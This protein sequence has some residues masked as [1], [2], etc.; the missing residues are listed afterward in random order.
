MSDTKNN[1]LTNKRKVGNNSDFFVIGIGASAGGLEALK[2]FFDNLPKKFNHALVIVQHLSPD[3]KSLMAD[4]LSR[5]TD[6]PIH[7]VEDGTKV[8]PGNIYLIPKKKNMT[9][10]RGVLLLTDKPKSFDLNL[11]IDIFF[12]SLAIDQKEKSVCIV[13]SGTG[14]DGSRGIRV[15][16]EFGGMLMVQKPSDA[17][18]DGMPNSAIATDL[19]DYILPVSQISPE[20]VNFIKHPKTLSDYNNNEDSVFKQDFDKLIS[21]VFKKTNIDFSDYKLPTLIRRVE[22]RMSVNKALTIREY[23]NYVIDNENELETLY[24]EF[25][26]GVTKFFRDTEAF[27]Y[28]E[29]KLIPKLFKDKEQDDKIKIW[30]VGC[31]SGEEAYSLAILIREYIDNNDLNIDVK[32]FATDLDKEAIIKAKKGTFTQSI[33]ADV[34]PVFLNKYFKRKDDLYIVSPLIRKMIIFSEHNVAQDPPLTKMDL[35]TCRNVLIYLRSE[36]QQKIIS[37]FHYSLKPN[38]FLF[39]GPSESIGGF[40]SSLKVLSRKW[41]VFENTIPTNTMHLGYFNNSFSSSQKIVKEKQQIQ[42]LQDKLLTETLS[43]TLL[44]EFNAASAYVDKDFELLTA[45]GNFRNFFQFPKKKLR[46]FNILKM[47]SQPIALALSTAIRKA[48]KEM[49]K[50]VYK[51]I[52]ISDNNN[53]KHER[54]TLVVNPIKTSSLDADN[55]YLIL[56]LDYESFSEKENV[57]NDKALIEK[58]PSLI[59]LDKEKITFLEQELKDTKLNLQSMVEQVETSNEELQA[60][61]EELLSSNEELQSTNEELQSL[62]EE[63]HTVNS[64]YQEKMEEVASINSDLENL[65]E[66]THIGTIFLDNDLNIRKFTPSVKMFFNI[67]ETDIGR[68][69]FHFNTSFGEKGD[70]FIDSLKEVLK[71]GKSFEKEIVHENNTWFLKRVNPFLNSSK[72]IEGVVISFVDITPLKVLENAM[73]SKN[74]FLQKILDVIPNILYIFNQETRITEYANK[75]VFIQLGY[76]SDEITELGTDM[77]P[78]IMHPKDLED[79]TSHFEKM[80]HSKEGE[81]LDFE[82]RLRHKNGDYRWFLSQ[83]TIFER[84][85]GSERVKH[86]GVAT[87]VTQLK[88]MMS[89]LE[90]LTYVSTHDI[91]APINNISSY[92]SLLKEDKSITNKDSLEAIDWI[93]DNVNN[94]N[95]ILSNLFSVAKA[96]TQVLNDLV[97][98]RIEHYFLE[99]KSK[100]NEEIIKHDITINHNFSECKEVYFSTMHFSSILDN[101]INNSIKYRSLKRDLVI[102]VKSFKIQGFD[103]ISIKDN[104]IGIDLNEHKENVFGLFKRAVDH[105]EGSGLALYL[106]K[107]LLEKTGGNIKVDSELGKGA[108]FT[109]YFKNK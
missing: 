4:L 41:R 37:S 82:Y 76:T 60:T 35:I 77:I 32:I 80:N 6:L 92:L 43:E 104:G 86:I 99:T 20:L 61:N 27:N 103:C 56:F 75:D 10:N 97:D 58:N 88:N 36:L 74:K 89:D 51:D 53:D 54:I 102:D 93:E 38:K 2:L 57:D 73:D 8:E 39:L 84:I 64:E 1:D 44:E 24:K 15:I 48:E 9:I 11:P 70:V 50:V 109:L 101:L 33:V 100:F 29:T 65:I 59:E 72:E 71:T 31:S 46:S 34:S 69:I 67:I 28:I 106:I 47:L 63:L 7:E 12:K 17:K 40:S 85:E 14:S 90:D 45:D 94:A 62:N 79:M 83:D 78:T 21:L 91:K 30:S 52:L 23:L 25:L 42:S 3:Y 19:V 55:I 98:I 95:S 5:N 49:K 13:L 107:K 68:S 16:K 81:I 96:R 18:F 26:I 66:S 105:I 108:T 87:D 22:R